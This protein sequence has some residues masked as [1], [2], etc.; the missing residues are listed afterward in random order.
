MVTVSST[1]AYMSPSYISI[2]SPPEVFRKRRAD[3]NHRG[4]N[5]RPF[6]Q[7]EIPC[8]LITGSALF[9][10]GSTFNQGKSQQKS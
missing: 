10:D 1:A 5:S 4:C 6:S 7:L 9:A 2:L 3:Q 8:C